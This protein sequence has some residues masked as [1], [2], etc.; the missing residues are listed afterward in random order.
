MLDL[1]NAAKVSKGR[2]AQLSLRE[3]TLGLR[4]RFEVAGI[5]NAALDARLLA[6][7][8]CGLSPEQAIAGGERILHPDEADRLEAFAKRRLSGEPVSRIRGWREFWGLRFEISPAT[9][10]PRPETEHLVEAAL[11]VLRGRSD[12]SR[13]PVIV[14]LGTG[15]GC[16]LLSI[17]SELPEAVGIGIDRSFAAL[18][19]ARRNAEALGLQKRASFLCGNWT[20][21]LAGAVADMAVCNPPY[22]RS[23]D[24]L[25]LPAE[26]RNFD[27][28]SALDGCEDGLECYRE[29]ARDGG[30]FLRGG[31]ALLF[32][33]GSGQAQQVSEAL[34]NR[35]F[36]PI[37]HV[38][39]EDVDL[40]GIERVVAGLRQ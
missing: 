36:L 30:R 38:S 34:K 1:A 32:E 27:P 17:L 10:D 39:G 23:A 9:L 6:A 15:S 7:T 20:A 28:E 33:V 8:A 29:I 25:T 19:V 11:S 12:P 31:A 37:A 40:A 2:P 13:R 22:I 14:D 16:I 35:G 18:Q 26:V 24:V 4:R 3:A 5:A 21:A